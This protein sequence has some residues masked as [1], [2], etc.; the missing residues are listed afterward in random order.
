MTTINFDI[1][2]VTSGAHDGHVLLAAP[3]NRGS[4][5]VAGRVIT[6]APW[7]VQLKNGIGSVDGVEPG[8]LMIRIEAGNF[9]DSTPVRVV[10]PDTDETTLVEL[11][12]E[13]FS[14]EPAI[15]SQAQAA[16]RLCA[17]SARIAREAADRAAAGV[18]GPQGEKGDPGVQGVPGVQGPRGEQGEPGVKGDKGERGDVGPAGPQGPRGERGERGFPGA[19][20]PR[21]VAGTPGADGKSIDVAGSVE[22]VADLPTLSSAETGQGY[23]TQD[24]GKLH[25]WDGGAWL[26]GIDIRG[27]QG[28]PGPQGVQGEPGGQGEPGP[29]GEPGVKGERGDV[30]E[31]GPAGPQ[32]EQGVQGVPG[33][34]GQP[35]SKGERGPAGPEGPRGVMGPKGD[36]GPAGPTGPAGS[37]AWSEITDK[38]AEV[39]NLSTHLALRPP[40]QVVDAL[41]ESPTSGTIYLVREK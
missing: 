23:F 7:R 27:P 6:T 22:S 38:P 13:S 34:A 21:G 9:V 26:P 2:D 4:V 33:P 36:T 32:G 11:L 40:V 41:P 30:G 8:P 20:G 14:Y 17:E 28:E 10:V 19:T 15:V 12:S 3:R 37:N 5:K 25:I 18:P 24:D 16:A 1:R 29:Q 35:G 39:V 31:R